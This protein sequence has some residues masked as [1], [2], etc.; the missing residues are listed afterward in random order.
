MGL[1]MYSSQSSRQTSTQAYL[2]TVRVCPSCKSQRPKDTFKVVD[3]ESICKQC[4]DELE[5]EEL[6]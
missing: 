3:G 6:E 1:F 5:T 2:G 4:Q